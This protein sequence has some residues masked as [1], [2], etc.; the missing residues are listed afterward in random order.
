MPL[1]P[2]LKRGLALTSFIAFIMLMFV[3]AANAQQ[4]QFQILRAEYGYGNQWADVT[5][6]LRDLVR[7]QRAFRVGNEALGVDPAVGFTK[8]LRIDARGSHGEHRTFEVLEGN[9]LEGAPFLNPTGNFYQGGDSGQFQVL[10]A[11]YGVANRWVDVTPRFRDLTRS[12]RLFRV[13]NDTLGIDPA[14]GRSKMLRVQVRDSR[15]GT[16]TFEY[17]EGGTVDGGQF[18]SMGGGGGFIPRPPNDSQINIISAVYGAGNRTVD[19]T[20]RLRSLIRN[21]RLNVTVNN[22]SMDI[23]PTPGQHKALTLVYSLGSSPQ[24]RAVIGEGSQLNL[25]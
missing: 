12:D 4:P 15:G 20:M 2:D 22:F 9:M 8:T 17:P 11:E 3:S 21:G 6:R 24:R 25:P 16:R 1:T 7:T 13:A 19:V 5:S 18:S 23:D 10:R 14:P